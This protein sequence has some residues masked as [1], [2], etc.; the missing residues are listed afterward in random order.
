MEAVRTGEA[1]RG[2]AVPPASRLRWIREASK[3]RGKTRLPC[4]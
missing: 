3:R 4:W 2:F 1:G